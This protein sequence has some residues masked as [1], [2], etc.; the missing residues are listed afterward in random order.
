MHVR[1]VEIEMRGEDGQAFGVG[2]FNG[3]HAFARQARGAQADHLR[4]PGRRQML[5]HLRA[6][7]SVER[8]LGQ[9]GQVREQIRGSGFK[10]LLAAHGNALLAE[11]DAGGGH[12]G[13][14][15]QLQELAAPAADVQHSRAAGEI[16]QI[17]LL[18]GL[19]VF[20]GTAETFGETGVIERFQG[21]RRRRRF[22]AFRGFGAAAPRVSMVNRRWRMMR[23]SV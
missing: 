19:D 16:V 23:N 6:E 13:F 15:H 3:E 10:T 2:S 7:Y 21:G 12:P 18:A 4:Q 11:I 9:R 20:F 5:H 17:E 1:G 22:G 14:P 8:A